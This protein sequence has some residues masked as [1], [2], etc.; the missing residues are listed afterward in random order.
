MKKDMCGMFLPEITAAILPV[1][2]EKYRARQIAEWLYQ[3]GASEFSEMTNLAK[4]QRE[5]LAEHFLI[6]SVRVLDRQHSQ[7]TKTS[8]FLL[9]LEDKHTIETV[10]MRQPYGNSVCVSTQVGCGMGCLFCA[11]NLHGLMRNLTAGEIL[12]EILFI[13]N[14]L[15]N[16]E[17]KVNTIVI[18]GS[19]EPLAN[20]EHVIKFIK[21]CHEEY[22]LN[23]SY[24]NI[25]LST[26]GLVPGI[27]RL[28][29]EKMPINLSISLHAPNNEI[30][31]RLMPV[32]RTFAMEKVLAAGDYYGRETGRRVT[33]EYT[34]IKGINDSREN[35]LELARKVAGQLAS[36]NLIPVNPV[37]ERGLMRPDLA[38]INNFEQILKSKHIN[39]TVR[40]EMGTDIQAACGQLRNKN[41]PG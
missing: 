34:L 19:G 15:K 9:E 39:V 3:R 33:Y 27:E 13:N 10:L 8:K 14:Y 4:K 22:S 20:Y 6:N 28:I 21:L 25:T 31:S 1:G 2:L 18:M 36:V 35:A 11:S 7:D 38:V 29:Q 41:L 30:R 17:E 16:Q 23:L 32:N 12:S 5:I 26:C 24:R 37:P 40:R